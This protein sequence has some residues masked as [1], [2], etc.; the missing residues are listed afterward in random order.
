MGREI[1]VTLH[2]QVKSFCWRNRKLVNN[3]SYVLG[4]SYMRVELTGR[5]VFLME[6]YASWWY[7]IFV[8][9]TPWPFSF[10]TSKCLY[11]EKCPFKIDPV[12][13]TENE[14]WDC[15]LINRLDL[16]IHLSSKTLLSK[17]A[18]ISLLV[19]KKW[20][21]HLYRSIIFL[22][23]YSMVISKL[24][25]ATVPFILLLGYLSSI[26]LSDGCIQSVV[27]TYISYK[28]QLIRKHSFKK[29]TVVKAEPTLLSWQFILPI[30][31]SVPSKFP[32]SYNRFF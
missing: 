6:V 13:K 30:D 20:R 9:S 25:N 19:P 7:V 4:H 31:L 11:N 17:Q 29:R 16:S 28:F 3:N 23:V 5:K 2:I 12:I 26:Q 21:W 27:G 22:S 14:S 15:S 10:I 18:R 24:A 1:Y 32:R 8:L